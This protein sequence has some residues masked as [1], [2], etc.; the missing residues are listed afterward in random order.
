MSSRGPS[1]RP[2]ALIGTGLVENG[3]PWQPSNGEEDNQQRG[4]RRL[5]GQMVAGVE[6]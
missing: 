6:L 4:G 3:S 2:N 5:R 1:P